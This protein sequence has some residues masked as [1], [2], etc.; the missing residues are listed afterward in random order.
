MIRRDNV[1]INTQLKVWAEMSSG[2]T[3]IERKPES[4]VD[5]RIKKEHIRFAIN[6]LNKE[7]RDV[8]ALAYFQGYTQSQ[9]AQLRNL[10]LGTV[11]TRIRSGIQKLRQILQE[12]QFK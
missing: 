1:R 8:L 11:K 3:S 12:E 10:P 2:P 5:L 9:I 6:Q 7:Q 4:A